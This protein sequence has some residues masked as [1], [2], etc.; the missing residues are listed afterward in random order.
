[1]TGCG[2]S[3]SASKRFFCGKTALRMHA[4]QHMQMTQKKSE[5]KLDLPVRVRFAKL[6][7]FQD[8]PKITKIMG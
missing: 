3:A 1:M 5:F 7:F 6:S 2:W 4:M 8:Q